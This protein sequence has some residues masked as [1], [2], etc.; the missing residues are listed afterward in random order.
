MQD[1]LKSPPTPLSQRGA[2][3]GNDYH[4]PLVKGGQEGDLRRH[5]IRLILLFLIPFVFYTPAF[6]SDY[7]VDAVNGNDTTGDGSEANPWKKL[8]FAIDSIT[9]T[10][11]NPHTI[12]LAP[13][14]YGPAGSGDESGIYLKSFLT[15]SGLRERT[16]VDTLIVKRISSFTT[17]NA[18]AVGVTANFIFVNEQSQNI[19]FE[20]CIL[21]SQGYGVHFSNA[22]S[23]IVKNCVFYRCKL[24]M[25]IDPDCSVV[26]QNTVFFDCLDEFRIE[27]GADVAFS[28]CR[29]DT[30]QPGDGNISDDPMFLDAVNRDFRLRRGSPCIDTGDPV[31]PVPPGGGTRIDMGCHEYTFTPQLYIE[32]VDLPESTG[33]SDG[34][35]EL[36]ESGFITVKLA[37]GGEDALDL[38]AQFVLSDSDMQI[39]TDSISYP[40]LLTGDSEWQIGNGISWSVPIRTGWCLPAVIRMDWSSTGASGTFNIPINLHSDTVHADPVLG[41]DTSGDGSPEWPFKTIRHAIQHMVGSRWIPTTIHAGQG[42]FSP[43]TNGETYPIYFLDYESIRGDGPDATILDNDGQELSMLI[44]GSHTSISDLHIRST[45]EYYHAQL[46]EFR[47]CIGTLQN[48][49][50]TRVRF[51]GEDLYLPGTY[52]WFPS[53]VSIFDNTL[54]GTLGVYGASAAGS[55]MN[56]Y[57]IGVYLGSPEYVAFNHCG[58]ARMHIAADDIAPPITIRHNE[59][60]IMHETCYGYFIFEDNYVKQDDFYSRP[61]AQS[62]ITR[63]VFKNTLVEIVDQPTPFAVTH[64]IMLS[65]RTAYPY[66]S[67]CGIN[68]AVQFYN[69]AGAYLIRRFDNVKLYGTF[70]SGASS[71]DNCLAMCVSMDAYWDTAAWGR[72]GISYY[73]MMDSGLC[74]RASYSDLPGCTLPTN[75]DVEPGIRGSGTITEIGPGYLTDD[76]AAWVPGAYRGLPVNPAILHSD[77]IFRCEDNDETTLFF[78]ENPADV[79]VIGDVYFLPDFELRRMSDGYAYDSPM[80]DAGNPDPAF[81][82]PDGTRCDIGPWGGPLST[83]PLPLIPTW[84][85]YTATPVISPTPAPSPTATP[86]P[87]DTP[88]DSPTPLSS[89]TPT[90]PPEEITYDLILNADRFGPGDAFSLTRSAVN[91][92]SSRPVF[93]IIVLDVYGSYYFWPE[94]T[95]ELQ[96]IESVLLHGV[97]TIVVLQFTWPSGDVGHASNLWFWGGC[98]DPATGTLVTGI[99]GADFGY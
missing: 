71:M 1:Q 61:T 58:V 92:G 9:G 8:Q 97:S 93:E 87:W 24:A 44:S 52:V 30:L 73:N 69:N 85:P 27:S 64:N 78:S 57:F 51:E 45:N 43:S 10:E 23:G 39:S 16:Q 3:K 95:P 17:Y 72:H 65:D 15:L 21:I 40:D 11:E 48:T 79:A 94:W 59:I 4:P 98:V 62:K 38:S 63:N 76:T 74:E 36:N 47:N 89:A 18:K 90:S 86:S 55:V 88:A 81:N 50:Q 68:S 82:D 66:P 20:N 84:P 80:I 70:N 7:Y 19:E 75:L 49:V 28:Y 29:M 33:D 14:H 53:E 13:G 67:F 41:N 37:N 77:R 54:H 6:A 31:D 99:S 2:Y 32:D 60:D 35:P 22:S 34:I 25:F 12:F 46:V 83:T 91:S 5:R 96:G 56:N 26:F 42:L